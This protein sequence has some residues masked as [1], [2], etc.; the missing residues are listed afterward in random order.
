MKKYLYFNRYTE[1]FFKCT[2]KVK[3]GI[4]KYAILPDQN[5]YLDFVLG[6][7]KVQNQIKWFSL[8]LFVNKWTKTSVSL[9]DK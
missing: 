5:P 4:M 7:S 2:W 9:V 3:T 6:Q 1:V 8:F